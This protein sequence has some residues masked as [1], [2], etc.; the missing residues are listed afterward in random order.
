VLNRYRPHWLCIFLHQ[1]K[2]R[3]IAEFQIKQKRTAE[4]LSLENRPDSPRLFRI[5]C[6]TLLLVGS[7]RKVQ[8]TPLVRSCWKEVWAYHSSHL[9]SPKC[10]STDAL[11]VQHL[12]LLSCWAEKWV[13]V[14]SCNSIRPLSFQPLKI[15]TNLHSDI[16]YWIFVL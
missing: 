10:H 14:P 9:G 11:D 5:S 15:N 4:K 16:R 7:R 1:E 12:L 2:R 3:Y 8:L 13:W 6:W